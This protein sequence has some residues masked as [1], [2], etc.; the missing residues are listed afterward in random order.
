MATK[1]IKVEAKK[2]ETHEDAE[3]AMKRV[4]ALSIVRDTELAAKDKQ[5]AQIDERFKSSLA[6]IGDELDELTEQLKD[7]SLRHPE[8]YGAR[9]SLVLTHGI[10]GFR[11]GTPKAKT[12]RGIVWK[13]V[14]ELVKKFLPDYV[15]T[16]EEVDKERL[17]ADRELLGADKLKKVGVEIVQDESFFIEPLRS[18]VPEGGAS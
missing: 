6:P 7:W 16:S 3:N 10:M 5:I 17:I 18:E 13:T 9:K 1:R 11:T 4:R 2:L 15:R 12:T 8:H 14:L